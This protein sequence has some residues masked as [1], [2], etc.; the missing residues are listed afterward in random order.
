MKRSLKVVFASTIVT[1]CL[2]LFIDATVW[3]VST[4]VATLTFRTLLLVG[5][6]LAFAVITN[7]S[8]LGGTLLL[9]VLPASLLALG[10][11]QWKLSRFQKIVEEVKALSTAPRAKELRVVIH[12]EAL[13]WDLEDHSLSSAQDDLP[14]LLRSTF[15]SRRMTVFLLMP[16]SRKEK[17][18]TYGATGSP[19]IRQ[20]VDVCAV[21]WPERALAGWNTVIVEPPQWA[22]VSRRDF[23]NPEPKYGEAGKPTAAWIATLPRE[24]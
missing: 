15:M 24:K 18:G 12:G 19:G 9:A 16:G 11:N 21:Y 10:L 17:V 23:R 4:F 5:C 7:R 13:V 6:L 8:D 3:P 14:F 22:R 1:L 2:S 20:V